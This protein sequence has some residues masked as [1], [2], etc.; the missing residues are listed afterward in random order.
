[1]MARAA[2]QC[3]S[4]S[5]HKT[6]SATS[7][8]IA[9]SLSELAPIGSAT[10]RDRCGLGFELP[11]LGGDA[12]A[13]GVQNGQSRSRSHSELTGREHPRDDAPLAGGVAWG[14]S[15]ASASAWAP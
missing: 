6:I 9:H 4:G 15:L 3:A 10:L 8:R 14:F 2:T 7:H 12:G 13:F 11:S 1:M 5:Q